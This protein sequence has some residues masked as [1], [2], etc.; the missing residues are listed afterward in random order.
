MPGHSCCVDILKFAT[1]VIFSLFGFTFSLCD[2]WQIMPMRHPRQKT[3]AEREE[4]VV[5]D[6]MLGVLSGAVRRKLT[7]ERVRGLLNTDKTLYI[8]RRPKR[9]AGGLQLLKD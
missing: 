2:R 8:G 6:G 5:V 3:I 1:E 4:K 9:N 7:G